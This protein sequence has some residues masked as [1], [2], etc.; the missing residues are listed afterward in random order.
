MYIYTIIIIMVDITDTDFEIINLENEHPENEHPENEHPENEH[1]ENEHLEN[2]H[3]E[4]FCDVSINNAKLKNLEE[5]AVDRNTDGNECDH[6]R[7]RVI[8]SIGKTN[9]RSKSKVSPIGVVDGKKIK[10]TQQMIESAY[11]ELLEITSGIVVDEEN[12]FIIV[13]YALQISNERLIASKTYKI[14]LALC[15]IRK[16]IDGCVED[17][18]RRR[19]LHVMVESIVPNLINTIQG[20]PS[21]LSKIWTNCKCCTCA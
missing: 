3:P 1:P 12:I 18:D 8:T 2:E 16:L 19:V 10:I 6:I 5:S 9:T 13:E 4:N 21:I 15:I 11:G 20:L 17:L 14:E 7:D